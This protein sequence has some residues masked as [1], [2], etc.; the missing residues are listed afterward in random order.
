M[1]MH[2]A[3][4][5]RE[6]HGLDRQ[7]QA[8]GIGRY[9]AT[10]SAALARLG[11][12]VTLVGQ[13]R[14]ATLRLEEQ[15][16][17]RLAWLPKWE[18]Q[19]A[20]SWRLR[21]FEE[22]VLQLRVGRELWADLSNKIQRAVLVNRYLPRLERMA[23]APYDVV[24]FAECGAEGLFYL[25]RRNRPP[26]VVRIHCPTQLLNSTNRN[27]VAWGKRLLVRLERLAARSTDHVSAPS[28]S[29][30][31]LAR[32]EWKLAATEPMVLSNLFDSAI[33][34]PADN[35]SRTGTFTIL[36]CGRLEKLKGL[37]HFPA[38]LTR[39]AARGVDFR[40]RLIGTDT[41]TAPEGTS[42]RTWLENAL[43]P[44]LRERVA[45]LGH[46][47]EREIVAE[48][49]AATVGL[50]LSAY[51]TF[52]YT[53]VEAQA[54][55]LPVVASANGGVGEVVVHGKTGFLVDPHDHEGIVA[56]LCRLH[57][58]PDLRERMGAAAS[59]HTAAR[60]SVAGRSKD[61]LHFYAQVATGGGP[62]RR[63]RSKIRPA[64]ANGSAA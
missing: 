21:R 27:Q 63:V 6:S 32:T 31:S 2:I 38:I 5:A 58:A 49:R 28:R 3:Y 36:Y 4:V 50:Y 14:D 26:C 51:E 44:A 17:V 54:C 25:L 11:A 52:G 7:G 34:S 42:M 37:L 43:D 29:A 48:L 30:A 19:T 16:G 55:G 10:M 59:H 9:V 13:S 60:F 40:V 18:N 61:F 23:E 47:G 56:F 39:L 1:A 41:A 33:F 62:G 24:E 46:L 22:K 15:N 53:V 8:G 35:G 20:L 45:F 64:S 57:D 12:R